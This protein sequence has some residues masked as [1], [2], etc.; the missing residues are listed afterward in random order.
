MGLKKFDLVNTE[1][2]KGL[3][4]K[5]DFIPFDKITDEMAEELVDKTHVLKRKTPAA[6]QR[7]LAAAEAESK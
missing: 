3:Q 7:A 2:L 4:Y 6:A 1:G 5:G